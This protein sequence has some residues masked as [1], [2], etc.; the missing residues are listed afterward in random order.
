MNNKS[1]FKKLHPVLTALCLLA[2]PGMALAANTI[3]F[4]GEV[5]DQTCE[6]LVDSSADP[7]VLLDSVPVGDLNG[8][9]G[10]VAGET[11]FTL[12]LTGCVAPVA[13]ESF[14]VLF[15]SPT[16]TAAGNL[17]NTAANG[18]QGVAL[19]ILDA[20]A[21]NPVSLAGGGAVA[22]GDIRLLAGETATS[23]DYAV[24]YFAEE[25]TVTTGPVLGSVTYTVRYE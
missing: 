6:A 8:Q 9:V 4:N 13:D 11:P 19:Q 23:Y 3:S 25:A 16:A 2:A 20:P 24:Q 15:Q 12:R 7:T 22:A 1:T 21:G 18:A 5:T 14:S 17:V 10:K